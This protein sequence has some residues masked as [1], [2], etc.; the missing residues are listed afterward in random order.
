MYKRKEKERKSMKGKRKKDNLWKERERNQRKEKEEKCKEGKRKSRNLNKQKKRK[1]EMKKR[2]GKEE[3][4][5]RN[6]FHLNLGVL[7]LLLNKFLCIYIQTFRSR[8]I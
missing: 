5:F 7:Y 2:K 8:P 1:K 4:N 6:R 3:E